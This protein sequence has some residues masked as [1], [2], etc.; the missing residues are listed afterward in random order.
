M[1]A[2][3]N[4]T[5][6]RVGESFEA[7]VEIERAVSIAYLP[8]SSDSNFREFLVMFAK[9][10]TEILEISS[11]LRV[12]ARF[13][14]VKEYETQESA[15][16][17]LISTGLF[18]IPASPQFGV[19]GRIIDPSFRTRYEDDIKG[20]CIRAYMEKQ[21]IEFTPPLGVVDPPPCKRE[22]IKLI[23]DVDIY[24][25]VPLDIGQLSAEEWLKE[26]ER[27]VRRDIDRFIRS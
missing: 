1:H 16:E 15:S 24:S 4:R 6:F 12:G 17:A 8:K 9:N 23:F 3:P 14:Y 26:S 25:T 2:E 27:V 5:I 19:K 13:F 18:K 21:N 7:I 10:V 11:I 22:T 20:A